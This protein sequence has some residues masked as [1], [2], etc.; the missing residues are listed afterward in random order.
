M[1]TLDTNAVIYYAAGDKNAVSFLSEH[2]H[3]I[4]YLPSIVVLEFLAYPLID[5]H[6][7]ALFRSFSQQT[8]IVNLDFYIAE[9]SAE[10]RRAYRVKLA[11]AVVAA[12]ALSTSSALVTRNISDFKK[13]PDISLQRI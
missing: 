13:I 11:D 1:F 8:T 2:K 3:E 5:S 6:A 7:A 10:I 12:T 4:F 9:L